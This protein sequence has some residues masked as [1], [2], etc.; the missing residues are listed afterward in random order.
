MEFGLVGSTFRSSAW[1]EL[2]QYGVRLGVEALE[3]DTRP[4]SHSGT[5]SADQDPERLVQELKAKGLR[6]G[7][8]L[9][10]ANLVQPNEAALAA[11]VER[12]RETMDLCFRYR[13]EVVRLTA[14][15][16]GPDIPLEEAFSVLV[17]GCRALL[18]Y[19]E[20]NALLVCVEPDAQLLRN[21]SAVRQLLESC[22]SYNLKVSLDTLSLLALLRDPEQVRLAVRELLDECSHV[23]L[24]DGT[25]CPATGEVTE[26]PLGRG[27][28]PVDMVVAELGSRNFYRPLYVA[29]EGTGDRFDTVKEGIEYFRDLPNRILAEMGL[30]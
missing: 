12:T 16:A 11:E 13:S 10:E 28:C 21:P 4:G 29:Y 7:A 30:L 3:L 26:V 17:R 2:L 5:W 9:V 15:R 18:E 8:V 20:E 14:Q 24:R 19:A 27:D 6:A 22:E 23:V 25:L 1:Q